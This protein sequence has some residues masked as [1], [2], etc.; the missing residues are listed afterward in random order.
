MKKLRQ[1]LVALV[2]VPILVVLELGL[3]VIKDKEHDQ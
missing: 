2:V 3:R 1:L